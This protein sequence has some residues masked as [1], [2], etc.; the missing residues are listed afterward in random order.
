MITYKEDKSDRRNPR[1]RVLLA[2]KTVGFIR[3]VVDKD[4]SGYRYFPAGSSVSGKL[5]RTI[6]A[7]KRSLEVGEPEVT[8]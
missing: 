3:L 7:V 5:Y 8:R 4:K 1:T 6:P 2:G